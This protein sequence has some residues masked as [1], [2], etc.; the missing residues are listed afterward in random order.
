M[1]GTQLSHIPQPW[2]SGLVSSIARGLATIHEMPVDA[3][4]RALVG[5]MDV[6][7]RWEGGID[8]LQGEGWLAEEQVHTLHR[9]LDDGWPRFCSTPMAL[10]HSD[11]WPHHCIVSSDG[12]LSG[13]IDFADATMASPAWDL[14][15][16]WI[17]FFGVG[18]ERLVA[19]YKAERGLGPEFLE[20]VEFYSVFWAL[21]M[22]R[23]AAEHNLGFRGSRTA[24]SVLQRH[25]TR[26]GA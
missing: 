23:W 14:S 26:R 15:F 1:P 4:T 11:L 8:E 20:E 16:P 5:E 9:M 2:L 21:R 17:T 19:A 7:G 10:T 25:F 24:L 12:E 6:P 3:A 13:F 18:R 22:P